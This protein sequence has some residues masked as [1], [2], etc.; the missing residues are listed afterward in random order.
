MR[1]YPGGGAGINFAAWVAIIFY[2]GGLRPA[3]TKNRRHGETRIVSWMEAFIW[4]FGLGWGLA[5][6]FYVN[7]DWRSER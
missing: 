7:N 3:Y 2:L 5:Q 4:P 1:R 6:T